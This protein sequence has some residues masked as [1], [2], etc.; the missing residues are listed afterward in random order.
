[1]EHVTVTGNAAI[2]NATVTVSGAA[3]Y[4]DDVISC[5]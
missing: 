2:F 3:T 4:K 5:R 1:M